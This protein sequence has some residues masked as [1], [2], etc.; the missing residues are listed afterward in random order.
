MCAPCLNPLPLKLPKQLIVARS[1]CGSPQHPRTLEDALQE[2]LDLRLFKSTLA[3]IQ[4]KRNSAMV[5]FS[6]NSVLHKPATLSGA[7]DWSCGSAGIFSFALPAFFSFLAGLD[8]IKDR[9][10]WKEVL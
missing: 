4:V 5:K 10:E 9:M 1:S 8:T 6:L 2:T 3:S 7:Y